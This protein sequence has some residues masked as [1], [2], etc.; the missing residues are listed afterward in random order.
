[1]PARAVRPGHI[2]HEVLSGERPLLV[3]LGGELVY[4][5]AVDRASITDLHRTYKDTVRRTEAPAV[6]GALPR[7]MTYHSFVVLVRF[8][9]YLGLLEATGEEEPMDPTV[10]ELVGIRS[11]EVVTA[12]RVLYRL[13]AKGRAEDDA[14]GNLRQAYGDSRL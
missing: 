6:G 5:S 8:A 3:K 4:R 9:V 10:P 11:G 7:T 13:T 1:M 2:I 12:T 14:W